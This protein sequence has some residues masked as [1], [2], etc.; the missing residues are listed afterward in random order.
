MGW[1]KRSSQPEPTSS[2]TSAGALHT[3]PHTHTCTRTHT[4]T[5]SVSKLWSPWKQLVPMETILLLLRCLRRERL[6]D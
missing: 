1:N 2:L 6:M 5:H 3:H 4:D